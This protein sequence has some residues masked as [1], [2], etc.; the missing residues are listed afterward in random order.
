MPTWRHIPGCLLLD[1]WSHPRDY[2]GREDLFLYSSLYSCHLFL[3]CCASVRSIP[4][5]SFFE[6]IFAWNVP[7]V[8]L[9]FEEIS[10][11][12]YYI[13]SLCFFALITEEGFLISAI[14]W[15]SVFKWAYPSFSLLLFTSLILTVI[16]KASSDRH[17]PFCISFSWG[18][19]CSL[20]PVQC[21]EP[22]SIV[23]QALFLSDL[24]P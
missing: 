6:P 22:S 11:L 17:F 12:S 16:C 21:H 23:R 14:L 8:T 4:F 7:L 10:S 2:L 24:I 1:E 18:S 13:F 20:S 19:S 5:L 15:N 3:V 9:N